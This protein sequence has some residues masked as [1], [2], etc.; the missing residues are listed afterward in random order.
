MLEFEP[1]GT[2]GPARGTWSSGGERAPVK[3]LF[4]LGASRSGS[5]I[6][7]NILG[8]IDGFFSAGNPPDSNLTLQ[9]TDEDDLQWTDDIVFDCSNIPDVIFMPVKISEI[10]DAR[11]VTEVQRFLLKRTD[12]GADVT[13]ARAF[14][15]GVLYR[16]LIGAPMPTEFDGDVI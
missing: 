4:I 10:Q 11:F 14:T 6:L 2:S 8:Q 16:P 13:S 12:I 1:R 3:V 5:T 7:G 15:W 9:V